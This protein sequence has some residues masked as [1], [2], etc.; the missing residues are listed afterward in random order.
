MPLYT[1]RCDPCNLNESERRSVLNRFDAPPCL[2]C[3]VET[4]LIITGSHVAPV[5][6]AG[7]GSSGLTKRFIASQQH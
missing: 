2:K 6:R 5:T 4:K 7:T 3:G 1:Y